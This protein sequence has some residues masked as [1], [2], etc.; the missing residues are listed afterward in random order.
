[1]GI[2]LRSLELV[3]RVIN[4]G[5][6]SN[7]VM[8]SKKKLGGGAQGGAPLERVGLFEISTGSKRGTRGE[9]PAG[10]GPVTTERIQNERGSIHLGD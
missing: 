3:K 6:K 4:F 8:G 7:W 9:K 5:G 2:G 1:M 10:K